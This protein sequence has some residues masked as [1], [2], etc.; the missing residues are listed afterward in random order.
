MIAAIA[1]RFLQWFVVALKLQKRTINR[2]DAGPY[3]YRWYLFG[4]PGG[5]KYFPADDRELRWWQKLLTGL[6]L[7]YVHRFVSSDMDVELHN[8]PWEATSL[9]VAGGYEEERR[10]GSTQIE[11]PWDGAVAA[12]TGGYKVVKKIVKPG[13]LNRLFCDTFHRVTLLEEDC[14]TL[15]FV[16]KRVQSWGF[17]HPMTGRF[18]EWRE[19]LALRTSQKIT[20][21]GGRA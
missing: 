1:R 11:W 9:I 2:D 7:V 15:I 13:S 19:H 3:L 6:P 8:H 14:W 12:T 4:E 20:A 18:L 17:W 21:K 16:G 5:L 10:V